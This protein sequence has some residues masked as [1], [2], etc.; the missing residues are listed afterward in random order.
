MGQLLPGKAA[1]HVGLVLVFVERPQ[2]AHL[3]VLSALQTGVMPG[4]HIFSP[5][6][7]CALPQQ[8][9]ANLP[10][11]CNAGVRCHTGRVPVQEGL[12]DRLAESLLGVD[13]IKRDAQL[14]GHLAGLGHRV[15]GAAAVC[16]LA[17]VLAPQPEHH[18]RN[19]ITLFNQQRRGD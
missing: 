4:G 8:P 6:R 3:S 11:A 12:H 2:Q 14:P 5:Q 9:P 16:I 17:A 18:P 7:L 19:R 13:H 10:V 1:E 15:R